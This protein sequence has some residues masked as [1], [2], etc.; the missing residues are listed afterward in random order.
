MWSSS[1]LQ[2]YSVINSAKTTLFSLLSFGSLPLTPPHPTKVAPLGVS[3]KQKTRTISRQKKAVV[4]G[5][6]QPS[7]RLHCVR[8][9]HTQKASGDFSP[10]AVVQQRRLQA[11]VEET[12]ISCLRGQI[13]AVAA[14]LL[15]CIIDNCIYRADRDKRWTVRRKIGMTRVYLLFNLLF[16]FYVTSNVFL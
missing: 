14:F 4:P 10:A 12:G 8:L 9:F 13:F 11:S 1:V 15:V 3:N 2:I 5:H 16:I 6:S 7:Y